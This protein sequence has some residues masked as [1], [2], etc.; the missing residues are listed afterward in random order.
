M[1]KC[2]K[3]LIVIASCVVLLL[4][5]VISVGALSWHSAQI[6]MGLYGSGPFY[7]WATPSYPAPNNNGILDFGSV[8]SSTISFSYS[9]TSDRIY[10]SGTSNSSYKDICIQYSLTDPIVISSNYRYKFHTRFGTNASTGAADA[11]RF[12]FGDINTGKFYYFTVA[13]SSLAYRDTTLEVEFDGFPDLTEV[14]TVFYCFQRT[15]TSG[16]PGFWINRTL[17]YDYVTTSSYYQEQSNITIGNSIQSG[18]NQ[19]T[20]EIQSSTDEIKGEIQSGTDQITDGW[21]SNP[22]TPDGADDVGDL[23]DIEDQLHSGSEQGINAG[24]DMI[25]GLGDSLTGFQK[26]FAFFMSFSDEL[27]GKVTWISSV[28]TIVLALGI[29]AFLL[30]IVGSVASKIS[31][32]ERR[33]EA[34]KRRAERDA[35]REKRNKR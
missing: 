13:L 17:K 22:V 26:G 34:D 28:L 1:R 9:S 15:S 18:S 31:R 33:A 3:C 35:Q 11:C 2:Y 21:E 4:C 20:G 27:L 19:I 16:N 10:F 5:S 8:S 7:M 24:M 32:D 12:Y 6:D 29:V 25:T 23:G 14:N 30:N